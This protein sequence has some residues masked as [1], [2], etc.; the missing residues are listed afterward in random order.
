MTFSDEEV[1]LDL[2]EEANQEL[3]DIDNELDAINY[4]KS[5][6]PCAV[7]GFPELYSKKGVKTLYHLP[8]FKLDQNP[9]ID[10]FINLSGLNPRKGLNLLLNNCWNWPEK[11]QAVQIFLNGNYGTGKSQLQNLVVSQMLAQGY[12]G[13]TFFDMRFELRNI[14]NHYWTNWD[15]KNTP[16]LIDVIIPEGYEFTRITPLKRKN[17]F[18][19]EVSDPLDAM[20]YMRPHSVLAFYTDCYDEDDGSRLRLVNDVL[21]E[22]QLA[23]EPGDKTVFFHHELST[24]I[25]ENPTAGTAK[26]TQKVANKALN[27]R[28]DDIATVASFHMLSEVFYRISQKFG[29]LLQKEPVNRKNPTLV[30]KAARDLPLN[31]VLV[32]RSGY[33]VP[34]RIGYYNELKDHYRMKPNREKLSYG[35][36]TKEKQVE[37]KDIAIAL[38]ALGYKGKEIADKLQVS[39]ST[40]YGWKYDLKIELKELLEENIPSRED[41]ST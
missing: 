38:Y 18:Y 19:R 6:V 2:K 37:L 8:Q 11:L 20:K 25:A 9:A 24:L 27:L 41:S 36:E 17:V 16:F 7:H 12:M 21:Y 5:K 26:L 29:I 28:K 34:H 13:L 3:K 4:W 40:V 31:G 30:E 33:W 14:A 35:L 1:P 32:S 23:T 39:P 15:G 10:S 22:L